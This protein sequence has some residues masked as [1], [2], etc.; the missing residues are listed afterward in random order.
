V[1][2]PFL[3]PFAAP[4]RDSSTSLVRGDGGLVQDVGA[5]HRR[6]PGPGAFIRP[7]GHHP[8]AF[9]PPMVVTDAQAALTAD[10]VVLAIAG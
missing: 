8:L 10:T 2:G 1:T 4:A 7:I 3:Q 5:R 6:A 9:R